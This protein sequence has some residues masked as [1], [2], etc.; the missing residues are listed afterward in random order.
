MHSHAS[1]RSN[2]KGLYTY[3]FNIKHPGKDKTLETVKKLVLARDW[4]WWKDEQ[5][6][7][8]GS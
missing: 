2:W 4:G 1:E 7:Y 8:R 6:E 3:N 5:A